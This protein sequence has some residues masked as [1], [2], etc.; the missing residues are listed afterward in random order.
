[1]S[2]KEVPRAGLIQAALAGRITNVQGADALAM[3]VRQ[4]RRLK[5]R[6]RAKGAAG[7]L[8][9]SRGR[10][11]P[12]ALEVEVRDRVAE[13]LQTRYPGLNDCHVTEKF[14]ELEGL[15]VSRSTVRRIRQALGLP[16]TRPRR[17]RQPRRRRTPAAQ[18]G[19]LVLIDG[20]QFDWFGTG[21][22]LMLVA[23]LDD[24]TATLLALEFRPAEDLHGYLTLLGH[25]ARRYGLPLRLYGD[26]LNIF[27]RNDPH[28]TLEEE[29]HG[30]RL[31][32][33]FGQ[34]LRDLGIG[35]LAAGSPQ[36]KGRS[37]RLWDTL[38]DRLVVELRLRGLTTPAAAAPFLP[39]F[40]ADHNRR[41]AHP[42][43]EALAVW[44]RPPPDFADRLSCRYSRIVAR[45]HTVQVAR[46]RLDIPVGPRS[47]SYAG[48]R[49][50][51]HECLDGRFRAVSQGRLLAEQPAPGPEFVLIPRHTTRGYPLNA[52]A[53]TPRRDAR[54]RRRPDAKASRPPR[55]RS[56]A[57]SPT[58]IPAS[59][60]PWRRPFNRRGR[61][62]HR[63]PK[64]GG[65][66]SRTS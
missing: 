50:T 54:D 40:M 17:P 65:T 58:P 36:A 7:L 66:F 9:Q 30:E 61:Q 33:H 45:D 10:P 51:V 53:R 42:A 41:F 23:A 2:R 8:H 26:R 49:V 38:Q 34:V 21:T 35:Y 43:A 1:M 55:R 63:T 60:H 44:R 29:L 28:W 11:S 31:P 59:G 64:P 24:A 6:F 5:A 27:V 4:F 20:S 12:R 62:I 39:E 37:E 32:T 56:P 3:T 16:P 25:L 47:R 15:E 46:R 48:C 13:L 19:A 22:P 57:A 52:P 14:Q 18:M